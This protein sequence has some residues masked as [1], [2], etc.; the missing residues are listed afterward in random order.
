MEIESAPLGL[1]PAFGDDLAKQMQWS[2]LVKR[3]RLTMASSKLAEVVE[4]LHKVLQP[5][6]SLSED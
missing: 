1:S 5:L 6:L 3:A 2:T 4:E